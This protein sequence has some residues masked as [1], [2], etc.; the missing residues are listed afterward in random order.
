MVG[1]V[2][3]GRRQ[4][5][6]GEAALEHDRKQLRE[7]EEAMEKQLRDMEVGMARERPGMARQETELK[8]LSAEIQQE[9]ELLQRG[10][11]Q[12]REQMQKFQRRASDVMQGKFGGPS[13]QGP[14]PPQPRR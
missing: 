13:Q 2:G 3:E 12:L 11:G 7:D 10:D 1:R 5:H 14:P 9:L 8:R 4:D 6:E